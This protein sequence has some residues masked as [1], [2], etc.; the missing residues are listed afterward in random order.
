MENKKFEKIDF[1]DLP[2]DFIIWFENIKFFQK[3]K[4][5]VYKKLRSNVFKI[6]LSTK[7]NTYTITM[8]VNRKYLGCTAQRK[9][10]YSGEDWLKEMDFPD[11]DL[12][13][14][15]F[16]RIMAAIVFHDA[17]KIGYEKF[18]LFDLAGVLKKRHIITREKWNFKQYMYYNR[19]KLPQIV[20]E[21][22]SQCYWIPNIEDLEADD[23]ID[24]GFSYTG[25]ESLMN[26]FGR[27]HDRQI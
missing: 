15:I 6:K 21:M 22:G 16:D 11:G 10:P 3:E 18:K 8:N 13:V 14:S 24:S 5:K 4:L 9:E 23:W 1:Y 20:N 27:Y 26:I 7:T 12:N 19:E 17:E 25:P 2:E